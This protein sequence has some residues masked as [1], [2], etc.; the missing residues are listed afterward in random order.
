MLLLIAMFVLGGS[1]GAGAVTSSTLNFQGRLLSNTGGLVSDG[2]YNIEFNLYTAAS[3]GV[4]QW[5]E[6]RLVSATQGVTVQNGYF[7]VYLG[8]VTAFP[9]TIDWDQ[10]QWLGMT[11]R[12]TGSCAFGVCTPTDAEMTPRFKLTAVPYAFR[13]GAVVDSSGN[14][15]TGDDLLQAAPS[16][17]QTLNAAVAALRVNQ[18]GSGGLLELQGSGVDVFTVD[19]TGATAI[20]AGLTLGNSTSTDAGTIRWT[21]TDFEGYNGTSW[22]SLTSG[23]GGSIN[24]QNVVK[25]ADEVVSANVTLQNDDDLTF[26]I[27]A[28]E[29]W[30][31]RFTTMVT[32]P[33]AADIQYAVTAPAGATCDVS[34]IDGEAA[35]TVANLG[36]GVTSGLIATNN[37]ADV[38]EIVGS[39]TN[40]A[41]AGNVTLQW[42]QQASNGGNTTVYAGSHLTAFG[43]SAATSGTSFD[44]NGNA[45]GVTAVLGT[46][47]TN[48]LNI[49]TDNVARLS[50]TAAGAA[51][52]SNA[53][54]VSSGGLDLTGGLDNNNGGIT[55]AGAVSGL[56]SLSG[57]GA[58]T[59]SS[60]GAGDLTLDSA[61]DVLVVEDATI[62]RSAAG[63]TTIDLLDASADTTLSLTNSDGT[64]VA[65]LS[66]EGDISANAFSGDGSGLTALNGSNITSGT[67][68]DGRL[69][70]NVAR[71]NTSQTFTGQPTFN[72][73]IVISNTATTTAGA[74]RWT[75]TDF[76]GYDGTTWVSL[77]SNGSAPLLEG[78]LAFGKYDGATPS[79]LNIDGATIAKNG[80]GDYTVTFTIAA[81]TANYTIQLTVDEP[82]ATLD[83]VI[84]TADNIST[85][86]F[87]VDV[88]EQD[89]NTAAGTR[90]DRTW[91]FIVFDSD[92][93][94]GGGSSGSSFNQGGNTFGAKGTLGTSDAFG[95]DI[96][97]NGTAALTFTSGGVANFTQNTSV[98]GDLT[99]NSRLLLGALPTPDASAQA[100]FYTGAAANEGLVI[101]GATAQSAN[102]FELQD[103]SGTTLSGFNGSGGLVLGLSTLTSTATSA[104]SVTLPDEAGA[105]CLSSSDLCGFVKIAAGSH[106]VD[107]TAND[108][109]AI[110]KTNATGNLISLQKNG[111]AVFTVANTGSLQIQSTSSTALDIRNVGG[112]SYFSVD[113][114]TGVTTADSLTV[115][116]SFSGAGLVD[117]DGAYDSVQ[118]D[119]TTGQFS[120]RDDTPQVRSFVDTTT[121]A[122]VDAD[123]TDYWDTAAENNNSHPNITP[124]ATT[125]SVVG[126]VSVEFS[127]TV[128]GDRDIIARVERGIGAAPTCGSGTVVGG[129]IGIFTS[130]IGA[131]KTGTITFLDDPATTS[132]VY[133]TV[134]SDA[135]TSNA[136]SVT[137]QQIRATLHEANN[138]N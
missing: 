122:L 119:V 138:T 65:G 76:E 90:V 52:F 111:G 9:T 24:L 85:T 84:I 74:M 26:A 16:A 75:G 58:L 71:L 70:A 39:V 42:A 64:R 94:A 41:T 107:A 77:T 108:L 44:Q 63:T 106:A 89:N 80:T 22:V 55:N 57:G 46:T 126:T 112:T 2:S 50:F 40:G 127:V 34:V 100:A 95:L 132:A 96:V 8:D 97:A 78:V 31:F 38:Y 86:S 54:T 18:T 83:D 66:V 1:P 56:T 12:G 116:N 36:C 103:S 81:A 99:A 30:T 102:L 19:N 93:V 124:S 123:T 118:W 101:Q 130:N 79:T 47:D 72:D 88:H 69:S 121:D 32:G 37:A 7:S 51:T 17:L 62:R 49:I 5:T 53:L 125:M 60:G 14:A 4:S 114:S 43:D 35:V 68:A 29:T 128:S 28:N 27:G 11:V 110:N 105:V 117:C 10:E 129:Q 136:G 13:A 91:N 67:I 137:L 45:F 61:T 25:P 20:G 15:Y 109:I 134:C 113:T 3:G 6:T 120:C 23:A 48:G 133:Y 131:R 135:N 73:G 21:G 87:D 92:A 82:T 33:G 115:T 104:W 98:T 59:V